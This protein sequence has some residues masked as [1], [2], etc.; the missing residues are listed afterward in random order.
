VFWILQIPDDAV[1]ISDD[2]VTL[3]LENVDVADEIAFLG[4]VRVPSKLSLDITYTK[5]GEPREIRP[6]HGA[7]PL[8]AFDWAGE[9]WMATNS[10]SFAV[11]YNDGTFSATGRFSSSGMFGEVGRER[12]GVFLTDEDKADG[13]SSQQDA[14]PVESVWSS[15]SA[16]LPAPVLRRK[17]TAK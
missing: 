6:K 8:G 1:V 17:R 9:M 12:N 10:G 2:T 3:H 13:E 11:S 15:D 7:D 16:I 4:T 14:E 5:S